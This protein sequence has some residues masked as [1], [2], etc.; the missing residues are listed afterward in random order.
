MIA[1]RVKNKDISIKRS[2]KSIVFFHC[3]IYGNFE[4]QEERRMN[5]MDVYA[6]LV[7][8]SKLPD[9]FVNLPT[10]LIAL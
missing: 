4:Q 8:S 9:H 3:N 1:I 5:R 6:E 2:V 10:C 7:I